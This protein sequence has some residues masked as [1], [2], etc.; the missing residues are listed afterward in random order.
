MEQ[1]YNCA[2]PLMIFFLKKKTQITKKKKKTL[3]NK[4]YKRI[5]LTWLKLSTKTLQK[6]FF[7]NETLKTFLQY[8]EQDMNACHGHFWLTQ[9]RGPS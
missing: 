4:R 9:Y 8:W 6:T 5:S 3:A 1:C 7:N 2:H